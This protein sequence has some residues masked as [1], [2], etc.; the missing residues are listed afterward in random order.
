MSTK[1]YADDHHCTLADVARELG[2][3]ES[4]A[5]RIQREAIEKFMKGMEARGYTLDA[6]AEDPEY[7]DAFELKIY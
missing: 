7:H 2:V 6:L 1:R 3:H 5:G 4:S